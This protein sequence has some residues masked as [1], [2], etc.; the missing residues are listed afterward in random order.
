ME[1]AGNPHYMPA[2]SGSRS[3]GRDELVLRLNQQAQAQ[4]RCANRLAVVAGAT[5]LFEEPGTLAAAAE[6]AR[7]WFTGHLTASA[8]PLA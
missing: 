5:H 3:I 1:H 8:H 2:P 4:L 7:D 6:L